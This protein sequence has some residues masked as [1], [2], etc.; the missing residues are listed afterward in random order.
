MKGIV[1]FYEKPGCKG[2]AKQKQ[3]L[4]DAGYTLQ[5]ID[6]IS[7]AWEEEDLLKFFGDTPIHQ[8]VNMKAPK[9]K[10]K[11]FEPKRLTEKE[12]IESML[13]EP[14]LIKRPLIFYRGDFA[15]GFENELVTSLLGEE[16]IDEP[17][18]KEVQ[19]DTA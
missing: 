16:Q 18:H 12:I 6:M 17:C 4:T 15:V 7:K 14:I 5:V 9:V 11:L 8:C 13:L 1:S 3:K 19:C 10:S 2:N